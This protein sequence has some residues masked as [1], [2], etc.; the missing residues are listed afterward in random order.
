[1]A[2]QIMGLNEIAL[3]ENG[4]AAKFAGKTPYVSRA[5][6]R[7]ASQTQQFNAQNGGKL[8]ISDFG[9]P[10]GAMVLDNQY[11]P[12]G[13]TNSVGGQLEAQAVVARSY[14]SRTNRDLG[15]RQFDIIE[16]AN[17]RRQLGITMDAQSL[18]SL[19]H[20]LTD[21]S[22]QSGWENWDPKKTNLTNSEREANSV[23]AKSQAIANSLQGIREAVG[24]I[25]SQ[26]KQAVVVTTDVAA[27]Q[28]GATMTS[29]FDG[30]YKFATMDALVI[31]LPMLRAKAQIEKAEL[32]DMPPFIVYAMDD[33][34][35]GFYNGFLT[36]LSGQTYDPFE[37][38]TGN[39]GVSAYQD[40]SNPASSTGIS[41]GTN[42]KFGATVY[43]YF[44]YAF[45]SD[46][47]FTNLKKVAGASAAKAPK[48]D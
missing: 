47:A 40:A 39:T 48:A 10:L 28:L 34:Y 12:M 13:R 42:G 8:D 43:T 45:K 31:T 38:F 36:E 25:T 37:P 7:G 5:L 30:A 9:E 23:F 32:D 29:N 3:S 17:A 35:T 16:P 27:L 18:L 15:G 33:F 6:A 22:L 21:G 24:E 14:I 1:M 44:D 2:Q 41:Y 11:E 20:P 4:Q 46:L 26:G 19:R